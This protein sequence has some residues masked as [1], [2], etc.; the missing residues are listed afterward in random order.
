MVEKVM[1]MT[2]AAALF[3]PGNLANA[4]TTLRNCGYTPHMLRRIASVQDCSVSKSAIAAWV[5][6][7]G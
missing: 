7:E 3:F 1:P 4:W 2:F 6:V 5:S